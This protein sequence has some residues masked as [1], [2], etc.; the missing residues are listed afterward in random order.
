M[1]S[2]DLRL[3]RYFVAV[4]EEGHLTRAASRLGIQ[5]P[6][7]SQQILS[8]ERELGVKLFKRMPRG[9]ELT[10]CGHSLLNDARIVLAK[11]EESVGTVRRIALGEQ[12]RLA[13]GFTESASLHPLL[14]AVL[15]AFRR[16][17]PEVVLS[18]EENNT[19]DLVRALHDKQLDVAFVRSPVGNSDGVSI[20][21]ILVE[22]MIVALPTSHRLAR[23]RRK[24]VALGDLLEETFVLTH[25]ANGP[26]FY[27]VIIAA[28]YAAGFSPRVGLETPKNLTTLSLVAAE[29]GVAIVPASMRHVGMTGVVYKQIGDAPTLWAPLH[30][31]YRQE[32]PSGAL[33]R[34]I[35]QA[36]KLARLPSD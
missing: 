1:S 10:E 28:C 29:M 32:S 11:M 19:P 4:A 3:L 26:G 23:G 34:L 14:P 2:I 12:G 9:M 31:A 16:E 22:P 27:D 35:N 20:E 8:L 24:N 30:I 36:R 21:R 33:A 25:R 7:L 6:P 15:R 18:V 17:V 5:Q 13:V